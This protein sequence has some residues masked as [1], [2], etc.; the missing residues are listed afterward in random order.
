ML[1][2]LLV[3]PKELALEPVEPRELVPEEKRGP[4]FVRRS[5]KNSTRSKSPDYLAEHVVRDLLCHPLE[6]AVRLHAPLDLRVH[7]ALNRR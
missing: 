4:H 6:R 5:P 7:G 1:G 3:A 2:E